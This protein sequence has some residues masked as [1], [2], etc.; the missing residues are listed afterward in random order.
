MSRAISDSYLQQDTDH[1][2]I[3]GIESRMVGPM[4]SR[5]DFKLSRCSPPG[6][7]GVFKW[8]NAPVRSSPFKRLRPLAYL[9][10]HPLFAGDEIAFGF[11]FA[12][13]FLVSPQPSSPAVLRGTKTLSP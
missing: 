11:H 1:K 13:R 2:Q 12:E 5:L 9:L 8:G 6:R 4:A 10:A 3:A 7:R